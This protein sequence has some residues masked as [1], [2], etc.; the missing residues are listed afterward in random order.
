MAQGS[1]NISHLPI[2]LAPTTVLP[3]KAGAAPVTVTVPNKTASVQVNGRA[4]NIDVTQHTPQ[5]VMDL[6][7]GA[8]IPGVSATLDRNG[9][10]VI[11]GEKSVGGD[12][13]LRAMLGI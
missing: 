8:V 10:L 6:I 1:T 4:I 2:V 7:N 3:S 5:N 13:T 12:A 9:S 11:A